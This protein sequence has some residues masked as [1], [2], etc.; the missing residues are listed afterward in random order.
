[1]SRV[2]NTEIYNIN[3]AKWKAAKEY[4]KERNWEFEIWTEKELGI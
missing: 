3:Q 4:C 2:F 1:M